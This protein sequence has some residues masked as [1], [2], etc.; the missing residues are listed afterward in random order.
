ML[1]LQHCKEGKKLPHERVEVLVIEADDHRGGQQVLPIVAVQT[2]LNLH[3]N[4]K[5]L[6][7][8]S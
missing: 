3:E 8:F 4:R 6:N 2:G 7:K 5:S 1:A